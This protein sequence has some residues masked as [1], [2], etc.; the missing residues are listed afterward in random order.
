MRNF[1]SLFLV[2]C[3]VLLSISEHIFSQNVMEFL[4]YVQEKINF[5]HSHRRLSTTE[6]DSDGRWKLF[7]NYRACKMPNMVPRYRHFARSILQPFENGSEE[8]TAKNS[9]AFTPL[10]LKRRRETSKVYFHIIFPRKS[11]VWRPSSHST[12][13]NTVCCGVI[14]SV[15]FQTSTI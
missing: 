8:I 6:S 5:I 1:D 15:N 9:S 7:R 10:Q 2:R 3:D 4:F 12:E 13:K 14:F 11:F